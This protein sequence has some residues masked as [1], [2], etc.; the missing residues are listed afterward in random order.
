MMDDEEKGESAGAEG[1][2]AVA[3]VRHWG[4]APRRG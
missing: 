4:R 2:D 3:R 1:E